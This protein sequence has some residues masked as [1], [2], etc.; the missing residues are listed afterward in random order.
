M[1]RWASLTASITSK[2]AGSKCAAGPTPPNTVCTTPVER[3]TAK[4]SDTRRS[5]TACI[6]AS[7]APSCITTN[8]DTL[9]LHPLP[10]HLPHLV[11]D[12]LEDAPHRLR[13]QGTV[14]V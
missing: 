8:I 4:P 14:V 3:C 10:L 12:A 6:W 11:D 5:I 9:L 2:S 1:I 7:V 13:A